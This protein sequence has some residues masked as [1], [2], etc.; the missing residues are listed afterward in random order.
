MN[1]YFL[2][3][4]GPK[5]TPG[6]ADKLNT[7]RYDNLSTLAGVF[8]D[9][10]YANISIW[11]LYMYLFYSYIHIIL[12]FVVLLFVIF[13]CQFKADIYVLFPGNKK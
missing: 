2:D 10:R 12:M 1:D 11:F 5:K 8:L 3:I 13:Y 4:V 6:P 9:Q 7:A